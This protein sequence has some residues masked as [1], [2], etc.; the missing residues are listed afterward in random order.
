MMSGLNRLS[1][2]LVGKYPA[3]MKP[4]P[5]AASLAALFMLGAAALPAAPTGEEVEAKLSHRAHEKWDFVLPAEKWHAV[6]DELKLPGNRIFAVERVGPQKLKVDTDGDGKLDSEVKGQDGFLT[7][8]TRG[9]KSATKYSVRIKNV[10]AAKWEWSTG[11]SMTGKVDGVLVHVFDQDG[12][13]RYDD[14]GIDALAVGSDKSGCLLSRV[15]QIKGKLHHLEIT[16][17]GVHVV[18]RPFEGP[19][20]TIDAV[21]EFKGKGK[22]STAV[23]RSGD[24]AFQVISKRK[25]VTIPVGDYE[26]VSGRISKGSSHASLRRGRM[27]NVTVSE[28][29]DTT[30]AWG[31]DVKGE[32]N[33]SQTGDQI[34]VQ[35]NFAIY[36]KAG[37]E[38]FDFVPRGKGPKIVLEDKR[39]GREIKEARFPES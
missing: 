30:V 9:D 23:F 8:R 1:H 10:G 5:I 2:K 28:G 39:T 22:L 20:G 31:A 17:D 32:F 7:L 36:G 26:F 16:D 37:E 13:G 19:T 15:V 18:T 35:P 27:A 29:G 6:G 34:T 12:N 25:S 24:L 14:F 38:Y 4:I 21:S 33:F 11:S 3:L